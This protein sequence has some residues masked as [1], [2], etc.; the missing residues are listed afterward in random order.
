MR[1]QLCLSC[2]QADILYMDSFSKNA[3]HV[4]PGMHVVHD[5]LDGM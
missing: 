4:S 2:T 1:G 5:R 3:G